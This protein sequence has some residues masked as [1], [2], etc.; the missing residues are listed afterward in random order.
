[1]L[2]KFLVILAVACLAA[3]ADK[4]LKKAPKISTKTDDIQYSKP[5]GFGGLDANPGLKIRLAQG[6]VQ[7]LQRNLLQYSRAFLNY[8]YN[9]D[10]KGSVLL[11]IFPFYTTLHYKNLENDPI[12]IDLSSFGFNLRNDNGK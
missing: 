10:E 3:P 7:T 5:N 6:W 12:Q 2:F 4:P 9:L 1:M 11:N 8:D